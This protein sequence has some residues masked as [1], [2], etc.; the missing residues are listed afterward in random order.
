MASLLRV[1]HLIREDQYNNLPSENIRDLFRSQTTRCA[2][3]SMWCCKLGLKKQSESHHASG[4]PAYTAHGL[5]LR[6]MGAMKLQI[7]PVRRA[8]F[9]RDRPPTANTAKSRTERW[10]LGKKK[11]RWIPRSS[12]AFYF[13]FTT[14]SSKNQ[15]IPQD[16]WF[17]VH[18]TPPTS[19][20]IKDV[21]PPKNES[22]DVI[23]SQNE[24]AAE[25]P[26][27]APL[28]SFSCQSLLH[29]YEHRIK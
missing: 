15:N 17:W 25:A 28:F 14:S 10:T 4:W 26:A 27:G 9:E 24:W 18:G 19:L 5:F 8:S 16:F 1:P 29:Q 22:G 23:Q 11:S 13:K 21:F 7:S 12:S 6:R 20:S 2:R 3:C